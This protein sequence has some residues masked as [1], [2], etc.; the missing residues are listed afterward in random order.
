MF[1]HWTS[2]FASDCCQQFDSIVKFG[3]KLQFDSKNLSAKESSNWRN[4]MVSILARSCIRELFDG[5]FI[6]W[7][8]SRSCRRSAGYLQPKCVPTWWLSICSRTGEEEEPLHLWA[9]EKVLLLICGCNHLSQSASNL[10]VLSNL[11]TW[12]W[13]PARYI[14]SYF[15]TIKISRWLNVWLLVDVWMF[16]FLYSLLFHSVYFAKSPSFPSIFR[17]WK[18]NALAFANR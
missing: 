5:N 15:G 2:F 18:R 3:E 12:L 8:S 4:E 1:A 13:K 7:E 11:R 9:F 16:S 6:R 10:L 14:L 17:W